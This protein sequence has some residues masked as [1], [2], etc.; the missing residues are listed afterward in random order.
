MKPA[1]GQLQAPNHQAPD[2]QV[3]VRALEIFMQ[4]GHL[5]KGALQD[6]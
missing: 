5:R 4:L 3:R 1:R 6:G 2:H